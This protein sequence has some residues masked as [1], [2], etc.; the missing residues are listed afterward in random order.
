ML[1]EVEQHFRFDTLEKFSVY[2]DVGAILALT[3][4]KASANLDLAGQIM[5][6]KKPFDALGVYI[7]AAGKT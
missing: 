5:F 7:I 1:Q 4:A 2:P 3:L 6:G